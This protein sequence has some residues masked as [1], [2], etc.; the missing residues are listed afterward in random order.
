MRAL[1]LDYEQL[2]TFL[3][4]FYRGAQFSVPIKQLQQDDEVL[5]DGYL[6]HDDMNDIWKAI[7]EAGKD[8]LQDFFWKRCRRNSIK[9]VGSYF[10]QEMGE[11]PNSE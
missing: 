9:T 4:T 2:C 10:S 5:F 1:K 8:G 7:G 6:D 3:G 11:L